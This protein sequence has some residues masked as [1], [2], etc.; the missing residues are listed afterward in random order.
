MSSDDNIN[1]DH[2]QTSIAENKLISNIETLLNT[3]LLNNGSPL[4]LSNEKIKTS[5]KEEIKEI[6]P[7]IN[8]I[9]NEVKET[10]V[11]SSPRN[12]EITENKET[13]IKEITEVK[14]TKE[15][16]E[17]KEIKEIKENN[18]LKDSSP[19]SANT[20]HPP[21]P[22]SKELA[23]NGSF[24]NS[25]K[26]VDLEKLLIEWINTL[27]LNS[28]DKNRDLCSQ[29]K[30]GILLCKLLNVIRP[31]IIKRFNE[32]ASTPFKQM[33]NI[34]YYLKACQ[35]MGVPSINLFTTNDLFE[36]EKIE[37][38]KI[39]M[40]LY[41]LRYISTASES[42]RF[43]QPYP[44]AAKSPDKKV[45]DKK[46][47]DSK[48]RREN[49]DSKKK[50]EK[51]KEIIIKRDDENKIDDKLKKKELMNL[52]SL[53]IDDDKK[54]DRVKLLKKVD[55]PVEAKSVTAPTTITDTIAKR[56]AEK[57]DIAMEE[58]VRKWIEDSLDE[59]MSKQDLI[60]WL[61]DG[62]VL[63]KL[64]NKIHPGSV[65]KYNEHKSAFKQ[66]ENIESYLAACKDFFPEI[67]PFSSPD[68]FD[69]K[70]KGMVLIH[71]NNLAQFVSKMPSNN[72]SALHHRQI[73]SE[74]VGNKEHVDEIKQ[75]EKKELL[76]THSN[77]SANKSLPPK[78]ISN[79]EEKKRNHVVKNHLYLVGMLIMIL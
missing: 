74:S 18:E 62:Q 46:L 65:K 31:G 53:N 41:V 19:R 45:E 72:S 3:S 52:N 17:N 22:F 16:K 23:R 63:C 42:P 61:K 20:S 59:K 67:T 48:K 58:R 7:E 36:K 13:E 15:I 12:I 30:D 60:S 6:L 5:P 24:G 55:K 29:L 25:M 1:S 4:E 14:E 9:Y 28:L 70:D 78:T 37:V 11:I 32:K 34:E 68:L 21:S 51:S 76:R 56:K 35:R 54:P 10:K 66:M 2:N 57:Y 47:E 38:S 50:D 75:T 33:E 64:M 71:L 26:D 8:D 39:L 40:N 79:N 44:E 49:D 43:F 69:E 27:I 73:R 77:L